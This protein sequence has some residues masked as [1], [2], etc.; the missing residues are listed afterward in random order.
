VADEGE[1]LAEGVGFT[2]IVCA[3]DAEHPLLVAVSE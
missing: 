3:V 2:V 1:I